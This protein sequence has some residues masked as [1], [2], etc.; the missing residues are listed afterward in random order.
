MT[1]ELRTLAHRQRAIL[2]SLDKQFLAGELTQ[3]YFVHAMRRLAG[4]ADTMALLA[5]GGQNT[6]GQTDSGP[7]N[8]VPLRPAPDQ[9]KSEQ[10]EIGDPGFRAYSDNLRLDT[11]R[12][13]PKNPPKPNG[14][15]DAA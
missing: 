10:P 11:L 4:I 12:R 15:G 2:Q 8:V 14:G 1:I 13:H 5:D 6:D 9:C 7:D 3:E